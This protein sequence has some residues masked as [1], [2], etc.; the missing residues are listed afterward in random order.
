[1]KLILTLILSGQAYDRLEFEDFDRLRI[2]RN[3]DCEVWIDNLGISRYHAEIRRRD[4][5]LSLRDL[6]SNNGTELNE[7]PISSHSLSSGDVIRIGKFTIDVQIVGQRRSETGPVEVIGNLTIASSPQ[8]LAKAQ[9]EGAVKVRGYLV[10][11]EGTAREQT[12][13]LERSHFLIGK[14]QDA[15]LHTA[16]VFAPRLA[17]AILREDRGFR[18]LD[19]SA[20]GNALQV[21]GALLDECRLND[22]DTLQVREHALVF[23]H[24]RHRED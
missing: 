1:M 12:W 17:A 4:D 15:D 7:V 10:C 24:G 9:E 13:P 14:D 23:R 5:H 19:L 6:D 3:E 21:N 11:N 18:A 20:K 8:A 16:G 22:G 2:G